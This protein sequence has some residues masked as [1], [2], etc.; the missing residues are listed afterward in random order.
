MKLF[1]VHLE[2]ILPEFSAEPA[3]DI[4]VDSPRQTENDHDNNKE[5]IRMGHFLIVRI[6]RFPLSLKDH[7]SHDQKK[8]PFANIRKKREGIDR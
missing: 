3:E 6:W 7:D 8:H 5:Y 4:H 2:L 1:I